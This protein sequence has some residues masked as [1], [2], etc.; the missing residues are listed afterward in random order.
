M[1]PVHFAHTPPGATANFVVLPLAGAMLALS[2][3]SGT[4]VP[5]ASV[6]LEKDWNTGK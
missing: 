3:W 6:S 2:L 1:K 5:A 4:R